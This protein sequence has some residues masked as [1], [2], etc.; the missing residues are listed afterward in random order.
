MI[1][2]LSAPP[3]FA[4]RRLSSDPI[5]VLV[6]GRAGEADDPVEGLDSLVLSGLD[7]GSARSLVEGLSST[8]V[9]D[10]WLT[11]VHELT[12]GNP[13]AIAELA[14]DPDALL[15]SGSDVPPPLSSALAASFTRRVRLLD[16]AARSALLV[17]V[18]CNGDLRLTAVVCAALGLDVS[19]LA[20][21]Q[22]AGLADVLGGEVTF[23]HPLLRAAM[24]HD[25]PPDERR[26]VHAAVAAA[27]PDD[28]VDRRA[29][30]LSESLWTADAGVAAMLDSA[31]D[32]AAAGPHTR[33]RPRRT[34]GQ[35]GSAR[36]PRKWRPGWCRRR[37]TP[38]PRARHRGR[39]R[40]WTSW[41][42]PTS[43]RTRR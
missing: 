40:C 17:A 43:R 27:L 28:D 9:S 24:Y 19:R 11:R 41:L 26:A 16:P 33:S 4:A 8:P 3:V 15:P 35:P 2:R 36:R 12:G 20:V 21:A 6:A 37:R 22:H 25:S 29:R 39:S 7:R 14:E 1:G 30:H 34:N 18:V 38:G 42:R 32:R 23:R 31:A 5:A 10:E 13:L